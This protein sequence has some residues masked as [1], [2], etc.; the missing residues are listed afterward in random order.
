[1]P[2]TS[3]GSIKYWPFIPQFVEIGDAFMIEVS[4]AIAG[5]QDV[6]TALNNAQRS[7]EQIMQDAGY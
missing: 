6:Q 7:I 5:T 4:A 1:M 2:A 3:K